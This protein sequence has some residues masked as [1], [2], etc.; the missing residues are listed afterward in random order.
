VRHGGEEA[1]LLFCGLEACI[2]LPG[3]GVNQLKRDLVPEAALLLAMILLCLLRPM[4]ARAQDQDPPARV[5]RL[6]FLTG[7]ISFQPA[8]EGDWVA[9]IPNRPLTTGD[10]LWTDSNSRAAGRPM[11]DLQVLPAVLDEQFVTGD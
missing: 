10:N 5:A 11:P 8:G 6:N 2:I 3:E 7:S 1:M 9:A 4:H